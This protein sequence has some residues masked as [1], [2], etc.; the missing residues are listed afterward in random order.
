MKTNKYATT[1]SWAI[2]IDTN[3]IHGFQSKA[4]AIQYLQL[5]FQTNQME[6][7]LIALEKVKLVSY[8]RTNGVASQDTVR[9]LSKADIT[10][11]TTPIT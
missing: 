7:L 8:R 2:R 3:T 9:G 4:E 5:L 1:V 6:P 11:I 10:Y